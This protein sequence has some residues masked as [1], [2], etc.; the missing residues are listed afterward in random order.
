MIPNNSVKVW[1]RGLTHFLFRM[2]SLYFKEQSI[3]ELDPDL[4]HHQE[5]ATRIGRDKNLGQ[6]NVKVEYNDKN[7][8]LS[9]TLVSGKDFPP[10]DVSGS[11]DTCV[12]VSVLPR[13]RDHREQTAIHRRSMNPPYNE[14]F[15][16]NIQVGEDAYSHSLLLIVYFY[17]SF[18]H[19][20]VLGEC[21]VPLIYCDFSGAT[22]VWCYLDESSDSVSVTRS[23]LHFL[24]CQLVVQRLVNQQI[25]R[26]EQKSLDIL[27]N[28]IYTGFVLFFK[29]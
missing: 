10:R 11:I 22:N 18:S 27:N 15:D 19:G 5:R 2:M 13:H 12:T 29:V 14:S 17:D 6:L 26:R 8:N 20:Y 1:V 25:T 4:Y 28:T 16:F 24:C 3:G 9:V 23:I 21:L 7:R